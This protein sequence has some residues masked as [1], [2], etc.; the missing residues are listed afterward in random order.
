MFMKSVTLTMA[1]ARKPVFVRSATLGVLL[2][3]LPLFSQVVSAQNPVIHWNEIAV[4]TALNGNPVTSPG[5]ATSGGTSVYLAYVHLAIF[6]AVNAID[7]RFQ[8]YGPEISA[9][10]GASL[11]AAVIAAA[12]GTLVYYFPDEAASLTTQYTASLGVITD[13]AAKTDGIQVGQAAAN[14][15]ITLRLSDGRG[16]N[17][18]YTYPAV[19]TAGVWIPTPPGFLS[20]LTPWAGQMQPFTMRNA[21]QFLPDEPPPDLRSEEW[22]DDFNKVKALGAVNSTIRT[23]AQREIGLFWTEHTTR[24]YARAFRALAIARALDISDTARLFAMVW[25]GFADSFIGCWN[26]KYHFSFWRPVTAI[27]NAGLAGNPLT[28]ADPLWTPLGTT[29]NHPEFPSAH[30]CVTGSVASS[31]EGFFH[32]REVTLVVS[33]TVTKTTHTFTNTKELEEEIFGARIYAG[34]HYPHSLV[35]GFELG[36]NVVKQM[37]RHYF[38]RLHDDKD[39]DDKDE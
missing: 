21:S 5:S 4:T 11:E 1:R 33:S 30:G 31:L 2:F 35:E 7:R 25:S 9:P 13:G 17:V 37:L 3:S 20:P 6:D 24:Q 29:P 39:E 8:S 14:G 23:A 38:R 32:T 22:A 34:F 10:Q 36:H 26:A 28:V 27:R 18:P 19:P 12:Y 15:I 16:A